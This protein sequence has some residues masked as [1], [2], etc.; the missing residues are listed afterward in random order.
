M[1]GFEPVWHRGVF[2]SSK[3]FWGVRILRV[4]R[5]T[6]WSYNASIFLQMIWPLFFVTFAKNEFC[7]FEWDRIHGIFTC[8]LFVLCFWGL[9]PPNKGLFQAK[10]GSSKGSRYLHLVVFF[11]GKGI[12]KHA[13]VRNPMR[14]HIIQLPLKGK[15]WNFAG[16][17][18]QLFL[19]G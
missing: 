15:L 9:N 14:Q 11:C 19:S 17:F 8:K 10:Q 13:N 18:F 7:T 5:K 12:G 6:C 1:E 3:Y 4:Y 2:G 16:D